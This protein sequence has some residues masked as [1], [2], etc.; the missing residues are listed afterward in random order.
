MEDFAT[1]E[2]RG[3]FV[4]NSLRA[5]VSEL[6]TAAKTARNAYRKDFMGKPCSYIAD[7]YEEAADALQKRL[8]SVTPNV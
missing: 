5:K 6:R 1:C 8:D 7:A 2:S 3:P 4:R